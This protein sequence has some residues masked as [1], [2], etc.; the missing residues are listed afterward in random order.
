MVP[1]L[2]GNCRD[3]RVLDLWG[4]VLQYV[5]HLLNQEHFLHDLLCLPLMGA[6]L[7]E[8]FSI[9]QELPDGIEEW[10]INF[11]LLKNL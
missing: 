9:R 10:D 1:N 4:C 8:E 11:D 6:H 2:V 5:I 7:F 3:T